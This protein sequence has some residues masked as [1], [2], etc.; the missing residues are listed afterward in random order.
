LAS[1]DIQKSINAKLKCVFDLLS[2]EN[3]TAG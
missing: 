1:K 3:T 2:E